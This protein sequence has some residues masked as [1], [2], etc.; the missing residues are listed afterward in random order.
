LSEKAFSYDLLNKDQISQIRNNQEK[1]KHISKKWQKT[2]C[3]DHHIKQYKLAH[4]C[5]LA[6]LVKRPDFMLKDLPNITSLSHEERDLHQAALVN[7]KYAGYIKK[8]SQD[9]AKIQKQEKKPIPDNINYDAIL[10]LRNESR[11]KLKSEQPKTL[12]EAKRIAGINPADI[13][14]LLLYIEQNAKQTQI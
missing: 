4:P 13:M 5:P 14:I 2:R 9:I 12:Y 10:G 3:S 7:D 1:I 11:E 6:H 8:Q